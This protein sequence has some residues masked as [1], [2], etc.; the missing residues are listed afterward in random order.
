[1]E[2][3]AHAANI[4]PVNLKPAFLLSTWP[5]F[6]CALPLKVLKQSVGIVGRHYD[7]SAHQVHSTSICCDD[8]VQQI[9]LNPCVV[10]QQCHLLYTGKYHHKAM[11]TPF[12]MAPDCTRILF[13]SVV[14]ASTEVGGWNFTLKEGPALKKANNANCVPVSTCPIQMQMP[15]VLGRALLGFC[16]SSLPVA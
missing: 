16:L 9:Q 7:L 5:K 4:L 8:E 13:R 6:H 3:E 11:S 2:V 14:F 10:L 12:L 1:L 15:V